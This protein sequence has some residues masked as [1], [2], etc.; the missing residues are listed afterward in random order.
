VQ[1][2]FGCVLFFSVHSNHEYFEEVAKGSRKWF[3]CTIQ[4]C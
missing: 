1:T 4:V 2:V 3:L